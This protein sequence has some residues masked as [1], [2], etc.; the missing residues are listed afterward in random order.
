MVDSCNCIKSISLI[1]MD[2][3]QKLYVIVQIAQAL[4]YLHTSS[5]ALVHSNVHVKP[6]NILVSNYYVCI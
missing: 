6:S 2:E 4:F 1:Q 3:V 5:P